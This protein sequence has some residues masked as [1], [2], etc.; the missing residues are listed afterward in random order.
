[1][2]S[3]SNS[4]DQSLATKLLYNIPKQCLEETYNPEG[5]PPK[6]LFDKIFYIPSIPKDLLKL[7]TEFIWK[8]IAIETSVLSTALFLMPL[9]YFESLANNEHVK[10]DRVIAAMGYSLA[11][12][13]TVICLPLSVALFGVSIASS[14]VAELGKRITSPLVAMRESAGYV[15]NLPILGPIAKFTSLAISLTLYGV[16]GIFAAPLTVSIPA[17]NWLGNLPIMHALGSAVANGLNSLGFQ[18]WADASF[19][20]AVAMSG[21]SLFAGVRLAVRKGIN[22]VGE[23]CCPTSLPLLSKPSSLVR[24]PSSLV[25]QPSSPVRQ[26][27]SPVRQPSSPHAFSGDLLQVATDP[28]QK[29]AGMTAPTCADYSSPSPPYLTLSG[30]RSLDDHN[31]SSDV[32]DSEPSPQYSS[33]K[34]LEDSTFAAMADVISHMPAEKRRSAGSGNVSTN[35]N[36]STSNVSVQQQQQQ[37][38]GRVSN[39]GIYG[40]KG[41]TG[42]GRNKSVSSHRAVGPSL[43]VSKPDSSPNKFDDSLFAAMASIEAHMPTETAKP[44]V[45]GKVKRKK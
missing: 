39:S 41:S 45:I 27:S 18:L 32:I 30:R 23:Y 44:V 34:K 14:L 37:Q 10:N 28:R 4:S 5:N 36:V 1:M 13:A 31:S 24:Q 9:T 21:A 25:R 8:L 19:P 6:T 22:F 33:S 26:P 43:A 40:R 15:D 42:V 16:V 35:A 38:P 12:I 3:H 20:A 2:L 7:G 11:V 17:S 29:H